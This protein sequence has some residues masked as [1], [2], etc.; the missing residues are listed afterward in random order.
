MEVS[1]KSFIFLYAKENMEFPP[2]CVIKFT[3]KWCGPCKAIN[4]LLEQCKEEYDIEVISVDVDDYITLAQEHG[5]KSIPHI[6]FRFNGQTQEV[7]TGANKQKIQDAFS[8]L[9]KNTN[10]IVL[11]TLKEA[12]LKHGRTE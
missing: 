7:I 3:A 11:P 5:V 10:Q 2:T 8:N 12:E 6:E 1:S 4:P 9:K